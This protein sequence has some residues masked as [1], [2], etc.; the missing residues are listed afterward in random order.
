MNEIDHIKEQDQKLQKRRKMLY[1]VIPLVLALFSI[2][3]L[4]RISTSR[5]FHARTIA[6]LDD[7]KSTVMELTAASTAASA[8]LTLLPGDTA[9]PIAEKLAD[10]S[11]YF[12]IVL[13]AIYVEKYLVTMTG[14]AAFL[15]LIPIGC[16]LYAAGKGMEKRTWERI[17]KK[18]AMF[19]IAIAV[20][21]PASVKV[22]DLIEQT[23]QS[24]IQDTID[25]AKKATE[26]IQENN[27]EQSESDTD[28]GNG[29]ISGILS[30]IKNGV[31]DISDKVETVLNNFIEALAV[32]LVTSCV[33]PVL[34]L[35]FFFWLAKNM[36]G[37]EQQKIGK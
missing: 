35:V 24:S 36:L 12:L 21:I 17:A 28:D 15:I 27:G 11:T 31:S 6:S 34:V 4:T 22:S 26:Q 3:V 14:Y 18:L 19:G 7:K 16:V 33:I 29:V 25:S 32:M 8:A 9:T 37:V 20:V 1:I 2:F 23:Y 30:G 10:I 5:S 13:C